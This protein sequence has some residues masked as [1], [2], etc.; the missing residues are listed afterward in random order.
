V[1]KCHDFT[2]ESFNIDPDRIY[3]SGFSNGGH[4]VWSIAG[5]WPDRFAAVTA[6]CGTPA[7]QFS[8]GYP[9]YLCNV[10][11]VGFDLRMGGRDRQNWQ[12]VKKCA[13]L[14]TEMGAEANFKLEE[15]RQHRWMT[16]KA[17][18]IL[19]W[20][21]KKKRALYPKIVSLRLLKEDFGKFYWLR[22]D[23][24]GDC[25]KNA[26]FA[27]N[28]SEEVMK[29]LGM[30][31]SRGVKM[32]FYRDDQYTGEGVQVGRLVPDSPAEKCGL[33]A[34][35]II[36]RIGKHEIVKWEDLGKALGNFKI[37]DETTVM[38]ERKGEDTEL[39]IKFTKVEIPQPRAQPGQPQRKPF[40]TDT[41]RV[42]ARIG[43]SNKRRTN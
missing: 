42:E 30:T 31:S 38:V 11:H 27:R 25:G 26:E 12:S 8:Y 6:H 35:D 7:I 22:V 3:I 28:Y 37:G 17:P 13:E 1:K 33:E 14:L 4:G 24:I 36:Y 9:M 19:E 20:F 15:E 41:S 10:R 18:E 2:L 43:R 39:K 23:E 32:G 16:D 5:F 40:P 29:S 34:G 21:G